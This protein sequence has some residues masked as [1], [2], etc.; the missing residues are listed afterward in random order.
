MAKHCFLVYLLLVSSS[1]VKAQ[2][3]KYFIRDPGNGSLYNFALGGTSSDSTGSA[4][5]QSIYTPSDFPGAPSGMMT[6]MFVRITGDTGKLADFTIKIGYTTRTKFLTNGG[7]KYD[8]FLIGLNRVF[9]RP[10][11]YSA[12]KTDTNGTWH[13]IPVEEGNFFYDKVKNFVVEFAFGPPSTNKGFCLYTHHS[14]PQSS[15]AGPRNSDY[16][17]NSWSGVDFGFNIA[18]TGIAHVTNIV[19]FGLF[20][21]PAV[22]GQFNISFDAKQTVADVVISVTSVT[23]ELIL[24]KSYPVGAKSFFKEIDL[25]GI[26]KGTY[27]VKVTAGDDN[28]TRSVFV[29]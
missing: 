29:P 9:S 15:L 25:N 7:S 4:K 24:C 18:T 6:H 23:G 10:G 3:P 14:R 11:G 17:Q 16:S 1:L 27:F 12:K 21:N 8:T 2:V 19:S 28:I 26:A 20:P 22:N 5:I 13:M